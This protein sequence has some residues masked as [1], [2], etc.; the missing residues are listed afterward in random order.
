MNDCIGR[1]IK[2][3]DAVAV[4]RQIN[5]PGG[6]FYG[7]AIGVVTYVELGDIEVTFLTR[8]GL[9]TY[10]KHYKHSQALLVIDPPEWLA[11]TLRELHNN[12]Y[13]KA[14]DILRG[15]AGE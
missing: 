14:R 4:P 10:G 12:S 1:Q 11:S 2:I 9:G 7:I 8:A 6:A 13:F 15:M 5:G 3:H